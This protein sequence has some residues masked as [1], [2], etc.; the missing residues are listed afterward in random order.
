MSFSSVSLQ[1]GFQGFHNGGNIIR[2]CQM[3]VHAGLQGDLPVFLKG[4]GGHADDRDM[5]FPRV[6]QRPD[7]SCSFLKLI[8]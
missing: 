8:E 2:F 3:A 6:F 4:V 1:Q 7:L 5:R